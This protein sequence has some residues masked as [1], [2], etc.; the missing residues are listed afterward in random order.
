METASFTALISQERK[1]RLR[2]QRISGKIN[3][4]EIWGRGV[5]EE[6]G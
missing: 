4:T 5:G 6:G 1:L 3:L 2:E